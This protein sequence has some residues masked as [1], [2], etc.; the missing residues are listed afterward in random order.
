MT[1]ATWSRQRL[2]TTNATLTSSIASLAGV[3]RSNAE[4]AEAAMDLVIGQIHRNEVG[5]PTHP[6]LILVSGRWMDGAS[7][8]A[9]PARE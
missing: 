4:V 6:H 8:R 9:S 3:A 2:S 5:I 1:T 7:V